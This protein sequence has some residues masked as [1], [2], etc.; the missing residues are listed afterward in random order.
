VNW[1]HDGNPEKTLAKFN[2]ELVRKS[3]L[4]IDPNP[5]AVGWYGLGL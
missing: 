2:E 3:H 4:P 1:P 5:P